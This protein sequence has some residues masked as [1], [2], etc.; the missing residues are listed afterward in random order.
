MDIIE[1]LP[2]VKR[3]MRQ[4]QQVPFLASKNMY[5]VMSYFLKLDNERID[6]LCRVLQDIK[7]DVSFCNR[8]FVWQETSLGCL[9]CDDSHRDQS[10]ICV[11]ESWQEL[12]VIERTEGYRGLY[13]VLGGVIS[14]LDGIGPSDLYIEQ[15]IN[16]ITSG[17]S[18]VILAMNQTPEGEA[19]A[20]FVARKL[21]GTAVK[22]SCLA[23]GVPIGSNLEFIDRLTVS[24]ALADR[25]PF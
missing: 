19:T 16:R 17:V 6:Q 11:V 23:K 21:K 18:E 10:Q 25:K 20:A 2:T 15:L 22:V 1:K 3:L 13:H 4:L 9:F 8:C 14:P 12:L 5:R 24:K 7:K